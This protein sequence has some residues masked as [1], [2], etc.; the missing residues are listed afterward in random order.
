MP[1]ATIQVPVLAWIPARLPWVFQILPIFPK[2]E[3]F[4]GRGWPISTGGGL[5]MLNRHRSLWWFHVPNPLFRG[6]VIL[7]LKSV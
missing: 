6:A 3:T 5:S 4:R 7:R 2:P 1:V